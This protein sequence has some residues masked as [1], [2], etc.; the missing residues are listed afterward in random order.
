MADHK[1]VV[2]NGV[3][4]RPEHAPKPKKESNDQPVEHRKRSPR[5]SNKE[6]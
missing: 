3:R 6:G 4:Y 1:M 5:Q 2:I